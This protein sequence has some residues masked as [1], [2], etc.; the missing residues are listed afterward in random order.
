V[1]LPVFKDDHPQIDEPPDILEDNRP[2]ILLE[3][4]LL[5]RG[6]IQGCSQVNP[7]A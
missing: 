3:E 6:L 7:T 4:A 2:T 5:L 1:S